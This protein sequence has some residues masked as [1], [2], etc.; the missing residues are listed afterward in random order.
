MVACLIREDAAVVTP[1]AAPCVEVVVLLGPA[2]ADAH[3]AHDE[4][5]EPTRGERLAELHHR[6]VPAVLLDDEELRPRLIARADHRVRVIERQSH[7][8]LADDGLT[9]AR[10]TDHVLRMETARGQDDDHVG[11]RRDDHLV[12][13]GEVW[14]LV[15]RPQGGG[16]LGVDVA[17]RRQHGARD[18]IRA[19]QLRVTIGDSP[20]AYK[21]K[22][23]HSKPH[24]TVRSASPWPRS[25]RFLPRLWWLLSMSA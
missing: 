9:V 10:E 18:L 2:P 7:G 25:K 15:L 22:P 1:R 11:L 5:A 13:V 16:A 21:R 19:E 12:H 3:G 23:Q 6:A 17:D 4:L 8:L 20:A 24:R 14:N